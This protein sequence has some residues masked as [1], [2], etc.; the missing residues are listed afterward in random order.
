MIRRS[1][2]PHSPGRGPGSGAT[3]PEQALLLAC[4]VGLVVAVFV[5]LGGSLTVGPIG[6]R[7]DSALTGDCP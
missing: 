1:A 3:R 2:A 4:V 6:D 5:L 7:C